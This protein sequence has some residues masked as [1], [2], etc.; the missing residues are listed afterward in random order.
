MATRESPFSIPAY[1]HYWLARFTSTIALNGMVVIIGWQVYDVARRT[2]APREAA[3]QLGLIGVAQ[4]LPLMLLTL[5]TGLAADRFDRRW[6]ARATT[7]LELSCALALGYLTWT[8]RIGLPALFTIAALLGVAR[9]FAAPALQ[10]LSP[11]LVPR[12]L[13]PQAI[14]MSSFAWQVGAIA[15]PPVG[16][17]LYAIDPPLAYGPTC[18]RSC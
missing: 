3:L 8:D 10:A 18:G 1:R 17:Y 6:I 13:L 9:A 14:A 5:V 7:A 2:M 11:N 16:G 4:F 12:P 15:G